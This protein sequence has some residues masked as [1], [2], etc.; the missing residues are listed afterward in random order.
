MLVS[1]KVLPC[2]LFTERGYGGLCTLYLQAALI[3]VSWVSMSSLMHV[4]LFLSRNVRVTSEAC[5]ML[6]SGGCL[7]PV[8]CIK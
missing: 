6:A 4:S 8:I 1:K 5:Q 2:N 3:S 7:R